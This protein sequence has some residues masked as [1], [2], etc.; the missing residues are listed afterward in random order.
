MIRYL[1]MLLYLLSAAESTFDVGVGIGLGLSATNLLLYAL[2]FT[3]LA[4]AVLTSSDIHIPLLGVHV[5]FGLLVAYAT[6][7]WMLNS[8]FDPTYPAFSGLRTLKNEII[9]NYLFFMVFFF[10]AHN[11]EEAKRIFLFALH[12]VAAMTVLT[13]IDASALVDLGIMGQEADGRVNGPIGN[14]NQ[15]GI[16]MAFFVPLFAAMAMGSTGVARIFW[17]FVFLCGFALLIASGSR[18]T[19]VG[20]LAG[21]VIGVRFISP[22]FDRRRIRRVGLQMGAVLML[23]TVSVA[24]TNLDLVAERIEQSTST[25]DLDRLSSGRTAIW[26]ATILVQ[27]E[28]PGS[29]LYGNGWNSHEQSGIWKSTHNTYLLRLYELGLIGLGM[30]IALLIAMVRQVRVL[31]QRT[32]GKERILMSGIA[33]GWFGV[34]VA[35]LFVDL[36]TPWFYIWSFLGMSLR[37]AYE[38]DR[39]YRLENPEPLPLAPRQP[40]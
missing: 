35:I 18:G 29:F 32:E 13:V 24:V 14:S 1:L 7:S 25:E 5:A 6:L 30:F 26:R 22:F 20:M 19:Y 10:G 17:W 9:D 16:F 38:K 34:I 28:N 3:I 15:Y 11:Y 31:V 27:A 33:F 4:R 40:A 36:Y 23:I 39:E 8:V 21:T 37:I 12:L 2:I